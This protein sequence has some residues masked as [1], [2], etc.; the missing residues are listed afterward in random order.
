MLSSCL[1]WLWSVPAQVMG[2]ANYMP[3]PCV[4][5]CPFAGPKCLHGIFR[6]DG[7]CKPSQLCTCAPTFHTGPCAL[8][9]RSTQRNSTSWD[10]L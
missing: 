10:L 6:M 7:G 1:C 4:I 8:W 2:D 9:D 5:V 3:S